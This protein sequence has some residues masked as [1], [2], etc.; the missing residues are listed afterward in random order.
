MAMTERIAG[1]PGEVRLS[2]N[3]A[4]AETKVEPIYGAAYLSKNG[5]YLAMVRR[6]AEEQNV[7]SEDLAKEYREGTLHL[8]NKVDLNG[9][10]LSR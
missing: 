6:T 3:G 8:A 9:K 10:V 4:H 2:S 7:R 1:V 5:P